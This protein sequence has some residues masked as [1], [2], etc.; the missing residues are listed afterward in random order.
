MKI[1]QILSM[2]LK[3]KKNESILTRRL[4]KYENVACEVLAGFHTFSA[5]SMKGFSYL[6][7][8]HTFSV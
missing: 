2:R 1:W 7:E 5:L 3:S 8:C 6:P 4:N